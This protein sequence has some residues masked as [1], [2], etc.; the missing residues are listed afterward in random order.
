M[1]SDLLNKA[2]PPAETVDPNNSTGF[3][4]ITAN[5]LNLTPEKLVTSSSGE[6][7][8]LT[9]KPSKQNLNR[10]NEPPNNRNQSVS[11]EKQITLPLT[12]P[13]PTSTKPP[14]EALTK[15]SSDLAAAPGQADK[16]DDSDPTLTD[17]EDEAGECPRCVRIETEQGYQEICNI[18][19]CW[20]PRMERHVALLITFF[21]VGMSALISLYGLYL[22]LPG[23]NKEF[24]KGFPTLSGSKF[25]FRCLCRV[26]LFAWKVSVLFLNVYF[27]T[28]FSTLFD[29]FD[30]YMDFLMGYRLEM[31]EVINKHIYRNEWVINFIFA[32]AFLGVIKVMIT[33]H[34]LRN[35][36]DRVTLFDAKNLC[37]CVSF[38]LE[39][40]GEM[41]LEYFY[42]E[43]YLSQNSGTPWFLLTRNTIYSVLSVRLLFWHLVEMMKKCYSKESDSFG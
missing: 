12:E 19:Q 33:L 21:P 15:H 38:L 10:T 34:I 37:Y 40:C 17:D 35:K 16:D 13:L 4:V 8:F 1:N 29:V 25:V 9:Q 5:N 36:S 27:L 41:F 28:I 32:F 26:L 18:T 43:N 31:G 6:N 11:T 22:L 23:L 14:D 39:D 3:N 24:R 7:K 30:V 20:V 2:T 42:I